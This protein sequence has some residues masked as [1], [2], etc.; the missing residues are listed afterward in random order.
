MIRSVT[1]QGI[2][3]TGR[4]QS[5]CPICLIIGYRENWATQSRG[6]K[7]EQDISTKKRLLTVDHFYEKIQ[8]QMRSRRIF[9]HTSEPKQVNAAPSSTCHFVTDR[10]HY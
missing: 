5:G 9:S 6:A 10:C 1:I 7:S 8:G 3:D 4:A 2:K